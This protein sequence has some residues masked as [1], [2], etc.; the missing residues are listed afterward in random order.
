VSDEELA[1]AQVATA[2]ADPV[3]A[4]SQGWFDDRGAFLQIALWGLALTMISVGAR[5]VSK[6]YRRDSIGMLVGVAPFL[7]ALYFFYQNVN[8]L[9]PPGI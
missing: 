3:D 9:L 6:R 8:R 1:E 7:F 4:F 2:G 5:R